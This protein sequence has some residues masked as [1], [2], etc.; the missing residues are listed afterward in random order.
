[1]KNDFEQTIERFDDQGLNRQ[2]ANRLNTIDEQ[3][4]TIKKQIE[5]QIE[6]L[7]KGLD[8]EKV[9]RKKLSDLIEDLNQCETQLN[10]RI[11]MKQYQIKQNLQV[12]SIVLMIF[13]LI[14]STFLKKR[15]SKII[16][17]IFKRISLSSPISRSNSRKPI[18]F[19]NN[20]LISKT[21]NCVFNVSH[22]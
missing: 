16:S 1:M 10:N 13:N 9:F 22:D 21:F 14:S 18:P 17:R 11:S 8:E 7:R 12:I 2:Y 20:K 5:N 19:L 6:H 15:M 4:Q 3:F